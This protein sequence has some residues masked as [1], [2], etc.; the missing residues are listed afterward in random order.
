MIQKISELSL[1]QALIKV[2]ECEEALI[3]GMKTQSGRNLYFQMAATVIKEKSYSNNQLK[4]MKGKQTQRAVRQRMRDFQEK[5]LLEI[6]LSGKDRR[7]KKLVPTEKFLVQLNQHL[8]VVRK[9]YD[10]KFLMVEKQ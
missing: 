9:I 3:A 4:T 1:L 6:R 8:T 2:N 10:E 5:G 7:M